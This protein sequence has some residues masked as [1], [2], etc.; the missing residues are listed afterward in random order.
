MHSAPSSRHRTRPSQSGGSLVPVL[1]IVTALA[2]S[3]II[4]FMF[5]RKQMRGAGMQTVATN[6]PAQQIPGGT[7]TNGGAP[8]A[9]K[10]REPADPTA[11]APATTA[12]AVPAPPPA[13]LGFARPLDLGTQL[14]RSL[15]SGDIKAASK[16]AS[17]GNPAQADEAAAVLEKIFKDMG[18]KAGP[19]DKVELL[20]QVENFTR[21]S[22]PLVK[23]GDPSA[24][25][26]LQIDLER[27]DK[28]GW[29]I[30]KMHLPKELSSALAAL[31]QMPAPAVAAAAPAAPSKPVMGPDG[32]PVANPLPPAPGK[33]G[34]PTPAMQK[35][36]SLFA[37]AETTDALTFASDFV[38]TLLKHDFVAAKKFI[39]EEKVPAQKL[40]GLCIVFE[41]GQYELKPAKPLIITVANPEVSWVIAQVQSESLQQSTEFGLELQ[42]ASAADEWRVAGLNLSEI[43]G[44]FAQ[45]ASKL[46][47]PYTPLVKNPKGG[48]SL[49][50]YF[51]YDHAALHPRAQKQLEIVAGLLKSDPNR[52]LKIAGHTDAMGADDYNIR[53]SQSRAESVKKQLV[54]LGVPSDQVVTTAMGKAQ[55]LG[56]NQKADGTDDPEGRSKNRRAEIFL[57]F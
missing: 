38:Q 48:E 12:P 4:F 3:A 29:K 24:T 27:D 39:N 10:L 16:L 45:S 57:D 40:I 18:Y 52:K 5:T 44:S 34:L 14:A 47:V 2:T 41:E 31:P 36:K 11:P 6:Q 30:A 9:V 15:G 7:P 55:P 19:D 25:L 49:A 51:E 42:R 26:R 1:I 50:L 32:K 33:T 56:P 43:L 22:I 37:V 54:A 46:G 23:P 53:L 17:A 20:G 35:S 8:A 28:M 21:L 13:S